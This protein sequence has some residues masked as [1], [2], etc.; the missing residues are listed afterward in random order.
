MIVEALKLAL[1]VWLVVGWFLCLFGALVTILFAL[2]V[3][4]GGALRRN[5]PQPRRGRA[6][7]V[8]PDPDD[9][10]VDLNHKGR[11]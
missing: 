8:V 5:P 2:S 4:I 10:G 9:E 1:Y 11:P 6:L 3:A 7:R